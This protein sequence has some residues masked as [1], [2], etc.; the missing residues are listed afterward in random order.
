MLNFGLSRAKKNFSL[1]NCRNRLSSKGN[2][3]LKSLKLQVFFLQDRTLLQT[4]YELTFS[5]SE[6]SGKIVSSNLSTLFSTCLNSSTSP[7]SSE[8]SQK[9][10]HSRFW[11]STKLFLYSSNVSLQIC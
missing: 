9:F 5:F 1:F 4:I 11:I 3:C 10:E 2:S 7:S 8:V 6:G